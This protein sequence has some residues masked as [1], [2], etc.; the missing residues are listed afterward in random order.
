[1]HIPFVIDVLRPRVA[2]MAHIAAMLLLVAVV[3]SWAQSADGKSNTT[4]AQS[5]TQSQTIPGSTAGMR[6]RM[7]LTA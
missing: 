1:M 4:P 3:C 2:W 5:S 6:M 7:R